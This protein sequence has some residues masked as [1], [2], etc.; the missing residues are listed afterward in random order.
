[1]GRV[2]METYVQNVIV[3]VNSIA[4]TESRISSIKLLNNW[5]LRFSVMIPSHHNGCIKMSR[6]TKRKR[7]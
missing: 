5:R 7:K 3:I 4:L 6:A 1:M 2:F